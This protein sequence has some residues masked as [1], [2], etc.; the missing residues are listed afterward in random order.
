MNEKLIER[1][2]RVCVVCHQYAYTRQNRMRQIVSNFTAYKLAQGYAH[3]F[4][5]PIGKCL[6]DAYIH[7]ACFRRLHS[8]YRYHTSLKF[9]HGNYSQYV[10]RT[11]YSPHDTRSRSTLHQPVESRLPLS[12]TTDERSRDLSIEE[13]L[14]TPFSTSIA[15]RSPNVELSARSCLFRPCMPRV[16]ALE[17]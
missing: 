2:K 17:Q 10:H 4:K 15:T 9:Q 14:S 8:R 6:L 12:N 3:L 1:Q 13:L 7:D 5:K 11:V 16:S